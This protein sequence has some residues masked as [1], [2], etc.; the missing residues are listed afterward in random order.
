MA[1]RDS[2]AEKLRSALPELR[3]R[4]GL[5]RVQMYGS[6]ARG[7]ARPD[8]DVDLLVEFD[9]VPTLFSIGRL[10]VDLEALLGRHVDIAT[11]GGMHP[12][13]LAA[14]RADAIEIAGGG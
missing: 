12:R 8:S 7:D 2:L 4:Y 6:V 3:R 14:A 13:V 11:P 10:Q 5:R 9:H 1:V